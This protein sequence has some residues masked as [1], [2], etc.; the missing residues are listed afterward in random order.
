MN[1]PCGVAIEVGSAVRVIGGSVADVEK[2]FANN[3]DD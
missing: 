2:G 3:R 1:F